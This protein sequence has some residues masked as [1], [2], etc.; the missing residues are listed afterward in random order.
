MHEHQ[1]GRKVGVLAPGPPQQLAERAGQHLT[2]GCRQSVDGPLRAPAF[3]LA[4]DRHDPALALEELDRV[5]ERAEVQA[6]E[7][8]MVA[9]AHSG[10]HLVWMDR[11]LVE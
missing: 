10:S 1:A 6:D 11:L 2:P 4:F 7:L 9:N 5:I 8:V 3:L